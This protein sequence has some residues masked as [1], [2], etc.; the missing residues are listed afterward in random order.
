MSKNEDAESLASILTRILAPL[1]ERIERIESK[2]APAAATATPSADETMAQLMAALRGQQ[3]ELDT[4]GLVEVLEGC[5][6]DMTGASFAAET[7]YPV[8]KVMGKPVGKDAARGVVRV[9]RSYVLPAGASKHVAEGGLVPD[10][11]VMHELGPGG[12]QETD[13]FRQ[14]TYDSFYKADAMRF[15]GKPL[16]PHVRREAG[17]AGAPKATG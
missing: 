12:Q 8:V 10:G 5:V 7:H 11:M 4:I 17:L 2:A 9:M 16:P 13:S 1:A 14:W 3:P 6:S 15:V